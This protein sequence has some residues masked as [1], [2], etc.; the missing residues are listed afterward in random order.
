MPQNTYLPQRNLPGMSCIRDHQYVLCRIPH[1]HLPRLVRS[2]RLFETMNGKAIPE[3]LIYIFMD[4]ETSISPDEPDIYACEPRREDA[5]AWTDQHTKLLLDAIEYATA[6]TNVIC[7][8]VGPSRADQRLL[9]D[10]K[11]YS[12]HRQKF[13]WTS[14]GKTC[15]EMQSGPHARKPLEV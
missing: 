7:K 13:R 2:Q 6:S 4:F 15:K 8:G 3:R 1:H 9:S 14:T 11:M 10:V 5:H 12:K